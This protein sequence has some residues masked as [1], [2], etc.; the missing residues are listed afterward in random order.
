MVQN[1]IQ[2]CLLMLA[3][4]FPLL[5]FSGETDPQRVID[6][7]NATEAD[8]VRTFDQL[9]TSSRDFRV[10]S[11]DQFRL[12]VLYYEDFLTDGKVTHDFHT[13]R[14]EYIRCVEI[15]S[16]R[17]YLALGGELPLAPGLPVE[18]GGSSSVKTDSNAMIG[19]IF[20]LDGSVDEQGNAR[21]CPAGTFP[22]LIP[23]LERF[24]AF[25]KYEDIFKK[26]PVPVTPL[27]PQD[28]AKEAADTPEALVTTPSDSAGGAPITGETQANASV[29]EYAH[30]RRAINNTG[31]IADFSVWRPKVE[32]SGE[33]SLS[34]LWV[35]RGAGADLQTAETGW[36]V[37][38]GLYGDSEPH[39]FIYYT[40]GNYASNTGCYNLSCSGFIQTNN[41][42]VIASNLTSY[43]STV[44]GDQ[45]HVTLGYFRD[46]LTGH[47]WL[48]FNDVW[49]GFYPNYLFDAQGIANYSDNIDF[50]GEIVNVLTGGLHTTTEMGSGLFPNEGWKRC[51][52][53]RHLQYFDLDGYAQDATGLTPYATN[54]NYYDI[55]LNVS[56][57][58]VWRQYFYFGGAGRLKKAVLRS[59]TGTI[60][61]T[62]PTYTWDAVSGATWYR[63]YVS[64]ATAVGPAF[65]DAWVTAGD[66]GCAT[67]TTCTITPTT[68][69]QFTSTGYK[70]LPG[71]RYTWWILAWHSAANSSDWSQALGFSVGA[72]PA[73]ATLISPS[74][75]I[76]TSSPT[77]KWNAVPDATW[78]QLWVNDSA[79]GPK[80]KTWYTSLQ[81]A[82]VSGTG[83]C[84]VTP[85]TSLAAG[86]GA[87]WIQT[88]GSGGAGPW[89]DGM[90]FT[91]NLAED[92]I[93][94]L[95]DTGEGGQA[96][97]ERRTSGSYTFVAKVTKQGDWWKSRGIMVGEEVWWL[98]KQADGH[99]SGRVL[100]KGNLYWTM[101]FDV[102]IRGNTMVDQTGKLIATKVN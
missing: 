4:M 76:T 82:C 32:Q 47:W 41:S 15:T 36:Q 84:S 58:D 14:N 80:I 70:T 64:S 50:G 85:A 95:W 10:E 77:Y 38:Q 25:R 67:S 5:L 53:T 35:T 34:Q 99:Y 21:V 52:D 37:Y 1:R 83:T 8:W 26:Y 59:P 9:K 94:G 66:A 57:Q 61:T 28:I 3:M 60:G 55:Q 86:S 16:Q 43:V 78:Y 11:V 40:T 31:S 81:T 17:S 63:F 33:F 54:S 97:M 92:P 45:H 96:L 22:K 71:G 72:G 90:T 2:C 62:T 56:T 42:V 24:F 46:R 12:I 44:S 49:V 13:A 65:M 19:S 18:S 7:R 98:S 89:S 48:K 100:V 79:T 93:V 23:P 88:W 91:V 69:L 39:L 20:G 75:S 30:A 87:W 6:P 102:W 73:K 101:P 74:G 27:R 29:H 51:A 68:N